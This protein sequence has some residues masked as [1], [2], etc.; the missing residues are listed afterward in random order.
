MP[1]FWQSC[2]SD[3]LPPHQSLV[4]LKCK[5]SLKK[6]WLIVKISVLEMHL[7]QHPLAKRKLSLVSNDRIVK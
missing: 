1:F 7:V 4:W 6:L 2:A 5:I 3:S